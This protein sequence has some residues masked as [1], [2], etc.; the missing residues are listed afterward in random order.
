ME[1]WVDKLWLY[2]RLSRLGWLNYRGKIML[3]AFVGTHV[4]LITLI[5]FFA[6][7][8]GSTLRQALT[9]LGVS[10]VATLLG[11][12]ATL[13]VLNQLLRPILM[14][15]RALWE[16]TT[17]RKLPN[18]PVHFSDEAGQLMA[19]A[20][21]TLCKLDDVLEQMAN[22][23]AVTGLSNRD[24]F[25]RRLGER[26][27]GDGS[28]LALQVLRFR[29]YGKIVS[30]FGQNEVD[31]IM[32]VFAHRLESLPG[33]QRLLARVDQDL[34]ATWTDS[35]SAEDVVSEF[36]EAAASVSHQITRG[37]VVILPELRAGAAFYPY[38]G[39]T[40]EE[41]LDNAV[42][43]L[44]E[45]EEAG[46]ARIGFFSA[47]SKDA[48]RERFMLEQD[49]R[50]A[51]AEDQF[52]L[53]YQPA[54]DCKESR[55]TG[56]EALIRWQH[57]ELGMVAPN[58]FIPLAESSGL[59]PELDMWVLRAACAELRSWRELSLPPLKLAINLSARHFRDAG[60]VRA[61][62]DTLAKFEV[63][64]GTL[65]IELTETAAM[66]DAKRTRDIFGNLQDMGLTIAIDDFG[67]G[68]S[69]MSYLKNL[70]FNKLKI[71]RE[72][73]TDVGSRRQNQAIC[74]AIIELAHGLDLSVLAE[75]TETADEV[76][77]LMRLGCHV[78]QG[79]YFSRPLPAAEFV[80]RAADMSWVQSTGLTA[81]NAA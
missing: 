10:L 20:S 7:Y 41:L 81:A 1:A 16:Y 66:E 40:P 14:T 60:L 35:G 73:V 13:F 34:F 39:G 12:G 24:R 2:R 68:Y 28:S 70:P 18:L 45:A 30:A 69:S 78:F 79:F 26:L 71:D 19:D 76:T 31:G 27:E 72:F 8:S 64:P 15:G 22:F 55:M 33:S 63:L 49:L 59:A 56:A 42:V 4:P 23:D 50:R 29:N 37:D 38:D 43:A 57:P 48:A 46:P 6:W 80:A 47:V 51:L 65:E 5:G 77:T 9:I 21:A 53:H 11:T 62:G 74:K 61:I 52:V 54:V 3:T 36:E 58:R 25:L 75:G 32:R 17:E 67:T 44:S